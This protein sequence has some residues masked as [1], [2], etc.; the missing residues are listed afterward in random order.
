MRVPIIMQNTIAYASFLLSN[1][2]FKPIEART[3]K[4]LFFFFQTMAAARHSKPNYH[5]KRSYI[6]VSMVC[7]YTVRF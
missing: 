5:E 6:Y 1:I 4:L 3:F 7:T 2:N